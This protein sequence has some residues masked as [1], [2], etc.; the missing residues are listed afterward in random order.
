[1]IEGGL[2]DGVVSIV[3]TAGIPFASFCMIFWALKYSFDALTKQNENSMEKIG[4]LTEAVNNNTVVLTK[5][6]ER[7]NNEG[8]VNLK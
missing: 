2:I 8:E 6:A 4:N 7:I 1:M 5:L 3:T